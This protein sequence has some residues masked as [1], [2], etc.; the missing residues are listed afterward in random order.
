MRRL[1]AWLFV[2]FIAPAIVAY[3]VYSM[4]AAQEMK[5]QGHYDRGETELRVSNL[6]NATLAL[7]RAGKDLSDTTRVATFDGKSIWLPAGNYFLSVRDGARSYFIP[8]SLTGYHCGPDGDGSFAA[9]IRPLPKEFPPRVS[10]DLPEF[11]YIPSGNSLLGDRLNPR[12]PH[13]VWLTG[14]FVAPFEVTNGEFRKF[15]TASDGF[16]DDSN[17]TEEGK[18]WRQTNTAHSSALLNQ[19]DSDYPR[20]GRDDQPI[21]LVTWY[22]ANAFCK[23]VTRH[24]GKGRWLFILPNEAEWEK[25]ARGPD[26]L[27]YS[28][29][30][31]ISDREIPFFNWR[32]NPDAQVPVFGIRDTPSQYRPNRFGAYHMCGNVVEWTQSINRPYNKQQPFIDDNRNL[33]A[34]SGLRVARGGSWYSAS[35][36]YLSIPYRD[37]F[38]PEHS[39][40]DIGFRLIAKSLP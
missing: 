19:A 15:L 26:N 12:E 3:V 16:I 21:T 6:S 9:T 32:K 18:R 37:A 35:I 31:F 24:I 39:T 29:S 30:M 33:D 27:D 22:E 10:G 38:Q 13:Y 1:P 25:V 20:F 7:F 17:W 8:V 11:I 28:L 2:G 34:T 4:V 23:W 5:D 36:A 40:Q 14:F